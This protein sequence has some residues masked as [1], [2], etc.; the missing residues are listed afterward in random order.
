MLITEEMRLKSR[1]QAT[2][3]DSSS[4]SRMVLLANSG[5]NTRGTTV[6]PVKLNKPYFNFA[7]GFC[8]FS[9]HCKFIHGDTS[10]G[11][12]FLWSTSAS[13]LTVPSS[14]NSLNMTQD[15]MVALIQTQQA[16]LAQLEYNRNQGMGQSGIN[17][18]TLYTSNGTNGIIRPVALHTRVS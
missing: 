10:N 14:T 6:A 12:P 4:S 16:I 9:D 17:T 7:K 1:A 11:I 18:Q 15:Q 8:R 2:P 13:R 3:I 5:N